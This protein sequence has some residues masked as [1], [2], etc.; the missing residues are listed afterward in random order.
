MKIAIAGGGAAGFFAAITAAEMHVGSSVTIF[1]K[2][3]VTLAKVRI[4]GGGRCN[5]TNSCESLEEFVAAYPRG[6]RVMRRLLQEFGNKE[7]IEWFESRGVPL[8]TQEDG[9]LFPES[10]NSESIIDCFHRECYRLN[11]KIVTQAQVDGITPQASGSLLLTFDNPNLTPQTFDKVIVT[12]GGSPKRR[13]LEWLEK[14]GHK[15]EEPVPSLFSLNLPTDQI[16]SLMGIVAENTTVSL[17][18]T[19]IKSQG[20]LLITHWGFSGPAI[21]KLSSFGARVMKEKDYSFPVLVNWIDISN[22]DSVK[23]HIKDIIKTSPG[24]LLNSVRPFDLP[25]RLWNHLVLKCEFQ[26]NVRWGDIG[27]KG[28]TKIATILTT[29]IYR[30]NGKSSYKDEFVTCGGISL[31]SV[32]IKTLQSKVVKNLYFAGELL[33]IDAITGGY[34]LQCAWTTGFVSGLLRD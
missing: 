21:L 31:D 1:E 33:D 6:G 13:G 20:A 30:V 3:H 12:T 28:V 22:E 19:K 24:K 5:L 14:L 15:I 16:T 7:T 8:V 9:C 23:E 29:D 34:N 4:T 10:Q 17:P 18:G 26:S 25:S 32:N 11:I 27:S 2:G